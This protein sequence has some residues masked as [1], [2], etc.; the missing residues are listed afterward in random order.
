L[1]R[2]AFALP[3]EGFVF[4]CFNNSYK[5]TPE[6]FNIWMKILA[7]V[8]GSCLWILADVEQDEANL[9]GAA[10][11]MGIHADRL[12]FGGRLPM[13]EYL[14]RYCKADLFLDTLPF[15][16]GTTVNDALWAGLPVLTR[17]G[18][19]FAGRMAASLL[20]TLELPE[21]IASTAEEYESTA[22]RLAQRPTE[23][24]QIKERLRLNRDTGPLFNMP[25]YTRTLELA[26]REMDRRSRA[27]L[28]PDHIHVARPD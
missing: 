17:P 8:E 2:S 1:P 14:G 5:I 24:A 15:N 3:D 6:L 16:G 19:S 11:R 22:V 12:V 18:N 21:L 25:L 4:C 28:P 23:L 10:E 13:T 26:F 20:K 9:R 7:S 27:G